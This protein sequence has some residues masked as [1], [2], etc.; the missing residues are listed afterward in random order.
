MRDSRINGDKRFLTPPP[1][2][3]YVPLT[4]DYVPLTLHKLTILGHFF[5]TIAFH[6]KR[7]I[8]YA[9]GGLGVWVKVVERMSVSYES[10]FTLDATRKE[11]LYTYP[12]FMRVTNT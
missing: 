10:T 8:C 2:P 12:N 9:S 11:N 3:D 6:A 1:P 4:H 5:H 7:D